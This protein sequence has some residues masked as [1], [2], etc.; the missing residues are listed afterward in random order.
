[1]CST[2]EDL[3]EFTN[4]RD[5]YQDCKKCCKQEQPKEVKKYVS[6]TLLMCTC[7]FG[8]YPHIKEFIEAEKRQHRFK[9]LNMVF[10]QAQEPVLRLVTDKGDVEELPIDQW[11]TEHIEEFLTMM[12]NTTK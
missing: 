6:A 8:R 11:K 9:N 12:L 1:M 5:V 3:K 7:K 2:C 10:P 4:N